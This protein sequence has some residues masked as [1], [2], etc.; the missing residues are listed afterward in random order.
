MPEILVT[1]AQVKAKAEELRTMNEQFKSMVSEL[2][3]Q[4]VDLNSMWEGQANDAFHNAFMRDKSQMEN[5]HS[6]MTMYIS[7]LEQI[8]AEYE[9]AEAQNMMIGNTRSY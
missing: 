6:V 4:E 9:K 1:A 8:A 3:S 7:T 5:F 2:E